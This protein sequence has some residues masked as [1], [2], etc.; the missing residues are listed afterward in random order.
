M[1]KHCISKSAINVC[2]HIDHI[3]SFMLYK[4]KNVRLNV[5]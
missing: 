2:L 3:F 1:S 4:K 5:K